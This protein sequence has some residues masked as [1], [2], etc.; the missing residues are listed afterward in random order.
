[1]STI[2][3]G[4]FQQQLQIE[5]TIEELVSAGFARDRISAF[6]VNPP[7][8]HDSFPIGGDHAESAGAHE[9]GKG[10]AMGAATGAAVGLAAAPFLGPVGAVT[11]SLVGAHL[12]GLA[13]GLSQMKE[14]GETGE[15]NEDADNVA[16]VRHSGMLLAVALDNQDDE[17]KAAD[18][19]RS[20]GAVELE[21]AEGTI[22]GGDWTDFDPTATP[23]ILYRAQQQ[24]LP[25][26]EPVRRL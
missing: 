6:Y 10:V 2:I 12:G 3:A 7:G 13:G 26:G 1:M 17:D 22:E 24:S 19:L 14:A 5:H 15:H 16:P 8:Q 21:R 25:P 20:L 18:L 9:S 11:G 4:R 23:H